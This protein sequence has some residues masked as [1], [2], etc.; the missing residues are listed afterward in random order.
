M[1]KLLALAALFVA[2]TVPSLASAQL[3]AGARLGYG[4]P[5]GD[6]QTS[7]PLKDSVKSQIPIQID[8]GLKLGQ[9][10]AVGA[11]ASYGIAQPS[12][13]WQNHCDAVSADCSAADLRLGA[14]VNLHAVNSETTEFWGGV[15]VGYEQLTFKDSSLSNDITFKGFDATLQGGFD[16]IVSPGLR[17]GPFASATVGQFNK[18][19]SAT[20]VDITNKEMHGFLTVG[21]RGLY[22][23]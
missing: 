19:K 21:V 18:L 15:A 1:R 14:Q 20:E 2:T 6:T 7:W 13:N 8:L 9:A 17:V 12:K 22:G 16:F 10:L 23:G 4:I 3:F 5:W 11:Y